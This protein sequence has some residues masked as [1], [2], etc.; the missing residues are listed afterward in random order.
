MSDSHTHAELEARRAEIRAEWEA[1]D[2]RAEA[3]AAGHLAIHERDKKRPGIRLLR[4]VRGEGCVVELIP[5]EQATHHD[6]A[7]RPHSDQPIITTKSIMRRWRTLWLPIN[8][9]GMYTWTGIG[10]ARPGRQKVITRRDLPGKYPTMIDIV[11]T[12]GPGQRHSPILTVDLFPSGAP[13]RD[14]K[15]QRPPDKPAAKIPE[16]S[17]KP[18]EKVQGSTK[19]VPIRS[20]LVDTEPALLPLPPVPDVQ[21]DP[22]VDLVGFILWWRDN[23]R[24]P[25][26]RGRPEHVDRY[27][28]ALMALGYDVGP[29]PRRLPPL[30]LKEAEDHERWGFP[31]AGPIANALRNQK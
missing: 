11:A 29:N 13:V 27:T 20:D 3:I 22:G 16:G 7:V 14:A 28:R 21:P 31:G 26:W 25:I 8:V 1:G 4:V 10:T 12:A 2:R 17:A 9:R 15:E 30:G 18:V 6:W 23:P 5:A 19:T 24:N